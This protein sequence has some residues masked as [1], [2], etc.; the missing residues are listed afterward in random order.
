M[1]YLIGGGESVIFHGHA[2]LTGDVD[3]FFD[4]TDANAR[5]LFEALVEFWGGGVPNIARHDELLVEGLILQF[6]R[7]PNRIDLLNQIGGV[8]F[9]EAWASRA[10]ASITRAPEEIPVHFLG[11]DALIRSKE[12]AGR[13]RDLEDIK[14]LRRA[15]DRR[16]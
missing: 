12:A 2:R 10:V 16:I 8:A 1:R 6:G 9:D 5:A 4:R 14:F 3:F 13:P 11:L 15:A 7:P